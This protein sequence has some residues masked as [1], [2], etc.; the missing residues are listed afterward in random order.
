MKVLSA[1][2]EKTRGLGRELARKLKA[3]DL[4]A[5]EGELGS[6]KTVFSRG[7]AEGLQVDDPREVRSPT[8]AIIQ[9]HRG[10]VPFCH[11]DLYRLSPAEIRDLGLEEYWE[12]GGW[13]TAVEWAGKAGDLWPESALSVRFLA[14]SPTKRE[15]TFEGSALWGKILKT[16]KPSKKS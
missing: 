12:Q 1:S 14:L 5:L 2:P 13:V 15:I 6:G 11:A 4:L 8:F 9:E 7:L 10:K 16:W 3:G